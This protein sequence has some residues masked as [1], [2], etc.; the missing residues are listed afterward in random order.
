MLDVLLLLSQQW[1]EGPTLKQEGRAEFLDTSWVFGSLASYFSCQPLSVAYKTT[2]IPEFL[3]SSIHIEIIWIL[4]S[5]NGG[6]SIARS[7]VV[8]SQVTHLYKCSLQYS[9]NLSFH[10]FMPSTLGSCNITLY[11]SKIMNPVVRWLL[12]KNLPSLPV[13]QIQW[14]AI[15]EHSTKPVT[16]AFH[17][18]E[19]QKTTS[20]QP[21]DRSFILVSLP[22]NQMASCEVCFWCML[23]LHPFPLFK[24]YHNRLRSWEGLMPQFCVC[25]Q[26]LC[27]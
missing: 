13:K 7:W 2:F 24:W 11:W 22:W 10:T 15:S 18:Q 20:I 27:P 12:W 5:L 25:S 3:T 23:P 14:K 9:G 4:S 26:I 21:Q 8:P 19:S 17:S 1:L 16:S 6:R